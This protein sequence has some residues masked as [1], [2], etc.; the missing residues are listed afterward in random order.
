[1]EKIILI[2]LIGL[3]WGSFLNVLIYRVPRK[4]SLLK[5]PSSCPECHHRIKFYHN[6]PVISYIWLK[7][8]C[9]YCGA[10]IPISYFIVELS[11]PIIFILLYLKFSLSLHFFISCLFSSAM[12]VLCVIDYNHQILPDIITLPG[13]AGTLV[14]SLF[15]S[16][17]NL[18][19]SLLGAVL[20]AGFLLL[21]YALYY[22]IRKKEGVGMG[23][24]T[25]MLFIG[26]YLGWKL[27]FFTLLLA[28]FVGA[29]VGI[30]MVYV[31]KKTFQYSLPFGTF[32]APAAIFSLLWGNEILQAYL[33][34]FKTP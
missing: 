14:Y 11:T 27:S 10:K 21:V 20:G 22:L 33:Q 8:K 17:L 6:I 15:R 4:M 31:K 18:T 32:L 28:S 13:L 12:V 16:D 29:A 24:V 9:R 2:I 26:S 19:E 34:L 7:G 3:A 23:D 5:P 25:I 30:Y 1:M